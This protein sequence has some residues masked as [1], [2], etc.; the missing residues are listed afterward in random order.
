MRSGVSQAK[1]VDSGFSL[2]LRTMRWRV[3]ETPNET[4]RRSER[5][6]VCGRAGQ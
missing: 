5:A 1:R 6:T 2:V 3:A 4:V